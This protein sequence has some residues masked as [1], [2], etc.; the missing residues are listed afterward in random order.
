MKNLPQK[1]L[2]SRWRTSVRTLQK[3]RRE[4]KGP[5]YIKLVGR[6]VYPLDDVRAYE[7]MR[8]HRPPTHEP[9]SGNHEQ[10]GLS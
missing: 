8:F 3:W 7:R 5:A 4:N 6:V 10:G 1:E 9:V 2:A